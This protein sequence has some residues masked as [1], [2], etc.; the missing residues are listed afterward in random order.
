MHDNAIEE[1]KFSDSELTDFYCDACI[2]GKTH[3]ALIHNKLVSKCT[4]PGQRLHWDT[5]TSIKPSLAKSIYM[6][7]G[8]DETTNFY[9]IGFHKTKDTISQTL[10]DTIT[11]INKIRGVNTVKAIHSDGGSEFVSKD[12]AK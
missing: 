2:L 1:I 7:I 5:C 3:R 8:V 6:V 11:K 10:F 4:I 12:T 9:F